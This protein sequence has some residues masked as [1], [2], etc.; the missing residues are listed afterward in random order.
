MSRS[1]LAAFIL[2]SFVFSTAGIAL[3]QESEENTAVPQGETKVSEEVIAKGMPSYN[4][5]LKDI[6][7]QAEA[8]IGEIDARLKGVE[9]EKLIKEHYEKGNALEAEGNLEGAK[10]EWDE[11]LRLAKDPSTKQQ[12]KQSE[13]RVSAAKR[14][15]DDAEREKA[16]AE[17]KA[18]RDA[19]KAAREE[20]KAKEKA[21]RIAKRE[22]DDKSR[23]EARIKRKED[24]EARKNAEK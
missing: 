24:E 10:A 4:S 3:C 21:E 7:K 5:S 22:A 9:N 11:A 16:E 14:E 1:K 18:K 12:I 17:R 19:E 15:K 2:V 20:A 13:N 23:E 8:K 6:I